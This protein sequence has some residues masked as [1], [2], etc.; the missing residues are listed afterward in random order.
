M[1]EDVLSALE[2]KGLLDKYYV[3]PPFQRNDYISWITRAKHEETRQKS[4]QQM[5]DEIKDGG[6]Y[7]K[8]KYNPKRKIE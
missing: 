7:M 4:L 5:I 6:L 2:N 1:P 3:R 8:M